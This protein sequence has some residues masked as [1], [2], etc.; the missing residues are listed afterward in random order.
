MTMEWMKTLLYVITA[1]MQGANEQQ[2]DKKAII[3]QVNQCNKL[4]CYVTSMDWEEVS[5][6]MPR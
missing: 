5:Q 1:T 3:R 2:K 4:Q 6:A